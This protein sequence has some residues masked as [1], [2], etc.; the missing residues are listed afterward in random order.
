MVMASL[1]E[2]FPIDAPHLLETRCLV[3]ANSGGGK[4][5]L[6]RRLLE[7]T[8]PLV[9]QFVIDPEGEFASLRERF[10][11]IIAAPVDGDAPAR[12]ETAAVLARRLLETGVSA[13]LDIY[14]LD[15]DERDQFVHNFL[16]ALVNA[17][18]RLWHPV[19]VVLDEAHVFCPERGQGS[20]ISK[21]A[22]VALASRGRKRGY[23][24]VLATQRLA[25]LHKDTAAELHN[26]CIG[27][28][29]GPDLK[30]AGEELSMTPTEARRELY[31]L[32]P[33]EFFV[34]GPAF[35][36]DIT[37]ITVGP[38]ET[39]H[40]TSGT[41][42]LAEPPAPSAKIAAM[43]GELADIQAEATEAATEIESLQEENARLRAE[44]DRL[45]RAGASPPRSPEEEASRLEAMV[46]RHR[47][48]WEQ[49]KNREVFGL[50]A[51]LEDARKQ[52]AGAV[53]ACNRALSAAPAVTRAPAAP[54]S[55]TVNAPET[56]RPGTSTSLP[57]GEAA[58]LTAV[59]Q[60]PNG[61][62][63]QQLSVLTVYKRSSRDTYIQ[64]LREKGLVE[65]R[66]DRV[67]A[68]TAGVDTLGAD[69]EPLPTGH[70][71][72]D[73]WRGNL[74]EGEGR[75]FDIVCN[76]YPIGVDRDL[77]SNATGY[78]RSSRDTYIQRLKQKEL[79]TVVDRGQVQASAHLFEGMA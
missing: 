24:L 49:E 14:E 19:M 12:P 61:C 22:V 2:G 74:P 18:K 20:A 27:R 77:I 7:Q 58:I 6:L 76:A 69:F 17:P 56:P 36:G 28:T 25:K 43:L 44:V 65:Q 68:T 64:R 51:A 72:R 50:K 11:Y 13:I 73:H 53:E 60:H 33:G 9:Q 59:A 62:T 29:G 71:L 78:K 47:A 55:R 39:T 5:W 70:A 26:K 10:D 79:V 63:R 3:Q 23:G 34:Y 67:Q 52:A 46:A 45:K 31:P 48:T 40:P 1:C 21:P 66:G 4:S 8:A 38:V 57:K 16:M 75:I 30:R 15:P 42:M 41:R 54:R 35:T 32:K 37:K